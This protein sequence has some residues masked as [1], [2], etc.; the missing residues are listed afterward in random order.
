MRLSAQSVV[1]VINR[2]SVTVGG[3]RTAR[4]PGR[5]GRR[6]CATRAKD[7]AARGAEHDGRRFVD[8]QQTRMYNLSRENNRTPSFDRLRGGRDRESRRRG[9]VG[10]TQSVRP[11]CVTRCEPRTSPVGF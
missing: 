2:V 11:R 5:R 3:V 9:T 4:P 6:A 8:V 1:Y 7:R 10:A